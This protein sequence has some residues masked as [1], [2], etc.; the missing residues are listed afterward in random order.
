MSFA[1]VA[2][3]G[4]SARQRLRGALLVLPA[5]L[6]TLVV[7]GG[8]IG[9]TL[10]QALGLMPI[11]GP[12]TPG[13]DAFLAHPDDLAAATGVSLAVAAVSTLI[14]VVVGTAAAVVIVSG[15]VGGRLLAAIGATT[16][17]VPH[18]V[19]AATIGLLLSDAGVLPRLLGIPPDAWAPWVGGPLWGAVIAEF[20]GRS[21]ALG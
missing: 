9:A 17:T 3:R 18:L 2:R 14:A 10:L 13:V 12:V 6:V 5:A 11:A 16:V 21:R 8:G 7:V 1:P 19:G 4:G 20:R 15:R